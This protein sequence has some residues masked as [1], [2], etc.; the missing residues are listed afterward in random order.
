M[1]SNRSDA[2]TPYICIDRR[3]TRR[4]SQPLIN[5][6]TQADG[7]DPAL[8]ARAKAGDAK[9]QLLV[10]FAYGNDNHG[11]EAAGWY[12]KAAE[13]GYATAQFVLCM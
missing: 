13:N 1:E 10:G 4:V 7:I 5:G 11:A 8:L 3:I 6:Q 2:A 9:S 12:Q